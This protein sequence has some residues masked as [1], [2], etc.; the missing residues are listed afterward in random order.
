MAAEDQTRDSQ[1]QLDSENNS[2]DISVDD[3]IVWKKTFNRNRTQDPEI[4][5]NIIDSAKSAKKR[6]EDPLPKNVITET[7]N[8]IVEGAI[9]GLGDWRQNYQNINYPGGDFKTGFTKPPVYPDEYSKFNYEPSD[10][11]NV[12]HPAF[13]K[14]KTRKQYY[15]NYEDFAGKQFTHLLDYFSAQKGIG[16]FRPMPDPVT[17]AIKDIYLG[18]FIKTLEENEDPTMLGF[19]LTIKVDQSPLF[20]GTLETFIRQFAGYGNS[21]IASRL[22]IYNKFKEQFNKFFKN[23]QPSS[24]NSPTFDGGTGV[25]TYYLKKLAGLNGLVE[26]YDSNES[27]QFVDYGKQFITLGFYEDVT[28]N[29]GH[30]A[31]LYKTLSYSRLNGKQ[32]IPENVLRFDMEITITEVKKYNR[33]FKNLSTNKLEFFADKISKYVYKIY[34]CQFFFKTLPH[35]DVIDMWDLKTTEDYEININYKWSKVTFKKEIMLPPQSPAVVEIETIDSGKINPTEVRPNE[36]TNN[37][38]LDGSIVSSQPTEIAKEAGGVNLDNNEKE[39]ISI[40]K[41]GE[42]EAVIEADKNTPQEKPEADTLLKD[43]INSIVIPKIDLGNIG[44]QLAKATTNFTPNL[45]LLSQNLNISSITNTLNSIKASAI[46]PT[47][48]AFTKNL[49]GGTLKGGNLLNALPGNLNLSSVTNAL[50]NINASAIA[51]T[52]GTFTKNL[53]GGTLKGGNLLNALPGNLNLSSVTNALKNINASAIAPTLGTFTKNLIGGTLK[54]GNLLNALPGNLNS[55]AILDQLDKLKTSAISPS[56]SVFYKDIIGGAST[57]TTINN[58]L[59][60]QASLLNKTLSNI[61]NVVPK[62]R[63]PLINDANKRVQN[64]VGRSVRGFFTKP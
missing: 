6:G 21:E 61:S 7:P 23:D 58:I 10:V 55:K 47:L 48:G 43:T 62:S 17:P 22:E 28:Q 29:I 39:E 30:L 20:N 35:G 41:G 54:G 38:I 19:D 2:P 59:T 52:L 26:V 63:N 46:A 24:Q 13:E 11:K 15:D 37:G 57:K 33:V 42:L 27:K 31:S 5:R 56:V 53:I 34:E 45:N 49:I 44:T 50:K 40:S 1:E 14:I 32:L 36:T 25:K 3:P 4:Y 8:Q 60:S 64:F 16:D 18:S 12:N 9:D 51:P